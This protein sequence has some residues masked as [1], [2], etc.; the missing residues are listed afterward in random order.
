MAVDRRRDD[1]TSQNGAPADRRGALSWRPS[2]AW[3]A[4][5]RLGGDPSGISESSRNKAPRE[6]REEREERWC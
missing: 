1:P 4:E 5:R 3:L 2:R 6:E